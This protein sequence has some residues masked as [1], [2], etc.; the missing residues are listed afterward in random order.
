MRLRELYIYK[1]DLP[2]VNGPYIMSSGENWSLDTTLVPSIAA[3]CTHVAATMRPDLCEDTR[4]LD[5]YI[6]GR[7]DFQNG[8]R[9]EKGHIP[10][11]SG[12][13]LG[14][15]PDMTRLGLLIANLS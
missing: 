6:D 10:L 4:I 7:F 14:V 8:V 15:T 5:S 1:D 9:I 3:A 13:G 12:P 11:P 2:V